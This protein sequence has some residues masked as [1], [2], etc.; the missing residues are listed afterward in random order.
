M[1]VNSEVGAEAQV[2]GTKSSVCSDPSAVPYCPRGPCV[3][4]RRH[5]PPQGTLKMP[6]PEAET[7]VRQQ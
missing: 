4:L 6:F 2:Y 5:S 7:P 1:T 3:A